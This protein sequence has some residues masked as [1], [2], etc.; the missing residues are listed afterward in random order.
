MASASGKV[1][2]IETWILARQVRSSRRIFCLASDRF[3]LLSNAT[4]G[5]DLFYVG[6]G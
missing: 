6:G 2:F 1:H 3:S 5:F 4:G